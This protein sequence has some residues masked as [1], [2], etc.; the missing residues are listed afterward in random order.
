MR[1][2]DFASV[3]GDDYYDMYRLAS[4]LI[5]H[6][7]SNICY[8]VENS[9]EFDKDRYFGYCRAV[10]EGELEP[11]PPCSLE[12]TTEGGLIH[13]H[14]A[15]LCEN[16]ALAHKLIKAM[17]DAGVAVPEMASV[18]CFSEIKTDDGID[19]TC[20]CRD[21]SHMAR[22]AVEALRSKLSGSGKG[23]GRISVG[24]KIIVGSTM[25]SLLI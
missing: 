21:P 4:L 3:A 19:I 9:E 25:R 2:F 12:Q 5:S 23:V 1:D 8:V 17:N 10:A 18:A 14:T 16:R 6:G 13:K 22:L 24:G 15:F 20:V 7:H 11:L